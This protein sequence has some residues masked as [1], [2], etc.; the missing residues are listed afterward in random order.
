MEQKLFEAIY[1]FAH[2]NNW[3]DIVGIIFA[4]V[5]G[6][7][8]ILLVGALLFLNPNRRQRLA[9]VLFILLS[10]LLSRALIVEVVQFFY[11]RERPFSLLGVE[12]LI[13]S[14]SG[15]SF[16][17]G[18][19]S[20]Y[21]ALAVSAYIA[22]GKKWGAWLLGVAAIIS[23]SRVF[24]GVHWVSDVLIGAAI[25]CVSPYLVQYLLRRTAALPEIPPEEEKGPV[26]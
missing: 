20:F 13:N 24:V 10:V 2:R 1:Q 9:S 25:G 3:L 16:P 11:F 7:F 23:I 14:A 15:A 26:V 4:D 21:F 12:P 8:A 5:V 19:A 17:S 18:H 22:I 6:Y